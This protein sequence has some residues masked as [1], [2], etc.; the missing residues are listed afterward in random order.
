MSNKV[1]S[2]ERLISTATHSNVVAIS[3]SLVGKFDF[4]AMRVPPP[5]DFLS[6]LNM[7]QA[8]GRSPESLI[9][10]FDQVSVR[11]ITAWS[12]P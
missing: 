6:F 5:R 12:Y 2:S 4:T 8:V 10:S 3:S 1:L 7:L 9:E 11:Q